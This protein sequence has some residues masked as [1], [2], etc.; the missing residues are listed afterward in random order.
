M[1]F[2]FVSFVTSFHI[3]LILDYSSTISLKFRFWFK[4]LIYLRRRNLNYNYLLAENI[5]FL[6]LTKRIV[7]WAAPLNSPSNNSIWNPISVMA[8]LFVAKLC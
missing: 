1:K 2:F 4:M 8:I 5:T 7:G 3:Q 6:K